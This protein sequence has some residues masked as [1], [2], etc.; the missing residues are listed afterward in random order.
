MQFAIPRRS[1]PSIQLAP[2][3]DVLLLL[4]IFFIVSSTFRMQQGIEMKLPQAENADAVTLTN[5]L[6]LG[7]DA[8]GRMVLN[9]VPTTPED[10][11]GQ[12]ADVKKAM[13]DVK[14]ELRADESV[15]YGAIIRAVDA[16]RKAGIEDLTAFTRPR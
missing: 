16:A 2:L 3:I 7:I 12:L 15:P 14:L 8:Q 4:L 11:P 13:P 1:N 5:R 6:V 9:G 10:L